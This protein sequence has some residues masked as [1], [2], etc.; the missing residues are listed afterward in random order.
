MLKCGVRPLI[1]LALALVAT[2]VLSAVCSA[3]EFSSPT[4]SPA[5]HVTVTSSARP[6]VSSGEP[7]QPL[8]PPPLRVN[9]GGIVAPPPDS[10]PGVDGD[11]DLVMRWAFWIAGY[12]FSRAAL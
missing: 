9:N 12:W 11:F 1:A 6:P 5:A 10:N 2:G 3:R 4:G 8:N 7:D